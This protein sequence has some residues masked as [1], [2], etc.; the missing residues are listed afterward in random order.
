MQ[1]EGNAEIRYFYRP[2]EEGLLR[3]YRFWKI[4]NEVENLRVNTR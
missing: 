1:G 2:I 3:R 4:L